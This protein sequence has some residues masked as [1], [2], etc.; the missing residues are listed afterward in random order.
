MNTRAVRAAFMTVALRAGVSGPHVKPHT[1]RHTVAWTLSAL[2][3]KL[4]QIADFVGH[5]SMQ[6]TKDVYIA[7]ESAQNSPSVI[8]KVWRGNAVA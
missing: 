5:R 3:N 6:V 4:E 2:G 8:T 1:T 7:M